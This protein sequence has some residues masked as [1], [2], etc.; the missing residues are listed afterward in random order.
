MIGLNV[1]IVISMDKDVSINEVRYICEK[2]YGIRNVYYTYDKHD[3]L[4]PKDSI[5]DAP[6]KIY[7][8]IF[9]YKIYACL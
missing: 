2:F 3:L 4:N 6:K 8:F 7:D 9:K 5:A 1:D